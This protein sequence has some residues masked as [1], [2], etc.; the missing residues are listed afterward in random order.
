MLD[1]FLLVHL[2]SCQLHTSTGTHP[3]PSPPTA[4][5]L[6]WDMLPLTWIPANSSSPKAPTSILALVQSICC[7]EARIILLKYKC[8]PGTGGSRL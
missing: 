7:T 5:T 4:I 1:F 2:T 8:V 3:S 6:L